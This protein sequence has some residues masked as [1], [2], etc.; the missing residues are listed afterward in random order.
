ML[1]TTL[2]LYLYEL[3]ERASP[4]RRS[5]AGEEINRSYVHQEELQVGRAGVAWPTLE[6]ILKE[7]MRRSPAMHSGAYRQFH[8]ADRRS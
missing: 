2:Y 7:G 6:P 4:A 1:M 3:S 5:S 8:R